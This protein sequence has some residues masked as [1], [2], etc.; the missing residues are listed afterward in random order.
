[1]N[2][3]PKDLLQALN[4]NLLKLTTKSKRLGQTC[5]NLQTILLWNLLEY[6][7]EY[8]LE[9]HD[10]PA[11]AANNNNGDGLNSNKNDNEEEKFVDFSLENRLEFME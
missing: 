11:E 2:T 9:D 6:A 3:T 8:E 1:M 10:D 5:E 7:Q 4:K